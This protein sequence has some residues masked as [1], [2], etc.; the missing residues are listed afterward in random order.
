M[1]LYTV[2]S[3]YITIRLSYFYDAIFKKMSN[4]ENVRFELL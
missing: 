2:Y 3:C 1:T 4:H